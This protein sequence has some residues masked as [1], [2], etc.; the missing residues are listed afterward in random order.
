MDEDS[1]LHHP[2]PTAILRGGPIEYDGLRVHPGKAPSGLPLY[3]VTTDDGVTWVYRPT[4][5]T[6]D[7]Y[8]TLLKYAFDHN[9]SA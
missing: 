4:S 9:E 1:T 2:K 7:E 6:D 5:E 8:P 3:K